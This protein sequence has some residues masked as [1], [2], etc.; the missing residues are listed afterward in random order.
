M[1]IDAPLESR[2]QSGPATA[3]ELM[4]LLGVSQPELSRAL[5]LPQR[6]GRVL[7]LGATR[8]ARYALPRSVAGTGSRWPLFQVD[9]SGVIHELGMVHA[10]QPRHYYCD[11]SRAQLRGLTDA[12][13]YFLQDQRP[14]GFLG[15]LVPT[16]CAELA[17]PPRV[18]DWSDDHYLNWLTHRGADCVGDLILGVAA[19]DHYLQAL[20]ARRSVAAAERTAAY[21]A[22]ATEAMIRAMPGS[23]AHGEHPKFTALVDHGDRR[24]QV[25][26]KFSPPM[27]SPAGQRW[28]DLLVAEHLA[29]VHL[30][31]NDIAAARSS[32]FPAGGR[33]FLEVE[34]FDRVGAEGRV[35]V[36]S[37]LAVDVAHFGMLDNWSRA[38]L[39]LA[40][41]GLVSPADAQQMRLLDAFAMQI[42][43]TDRHFGNLALY[44]RYTGRHELAP[45]YDMLPMLFAPQNDQL[46]ERTFAP[47]DPSAEGL[48]VWSRARDLAEQYW[49]MLMADARI[50]GDFRA[51]CE[52]SLRVLRLSPRRFPT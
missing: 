5:K 8:G 16:S 22:L 12:V 9:A 2:L 26:V 27:D 52:Q 4:Q 17:L 32:V 30:H 48:A 39:R 10:L 18:V 31:A 29:H 38:A 50:S 25:I 42:G 13:P 41:H 20:K 49:A 46:I 44:D 51:I 7:K 23:S 19:F 43:N 1:E 6:D 11:S 28:A 36:V 34:R 15:R 35:G 45:V 37:L 33:M 40:H 24:V 47:P 21:P 3:A 14:A